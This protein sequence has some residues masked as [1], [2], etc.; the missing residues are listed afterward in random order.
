[1]KKRVEAAKKRSAQLKKLFPRRSLVT[2]SMAR[3]GGDATCFGIVSVRGARGS[4]SGGGE[5]ASDGRTRKAFVGSNE[6][7]LLRALL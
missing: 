4:G 7:E 1:M 6:S 3:R 2:E 5:A